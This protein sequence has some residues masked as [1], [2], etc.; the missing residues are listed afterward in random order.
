MSIL[1]EPRCE[2]TGLLGFRP[3]PIQTRLYNR[4]RCIEASNFL[5]RKKR[6]C[7]IYVVKTK[8][9]IS[10]VITSKLIC[11]FVFLYSQKTKFSHGAAYI[12]AMCQEG[13]IKMLEI[14]S[15]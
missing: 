6:N 14:S 7:T 5:F 11:V 13:Q 10:F 8:E 3:D 15:V 1:Y 2:K 4:I 12:R 9:L